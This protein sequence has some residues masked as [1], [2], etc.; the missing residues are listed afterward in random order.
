MSG[1][2]K[3]YLSMK[4]KNH[5][6]SDFTS[7]CTITLLVTSMHVCIPDYQSNRCNVISLSEI[8]GVDPSFYFKGV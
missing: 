7:R 3:V 8:H 4:H 5:L 1:D 6:S 2:A